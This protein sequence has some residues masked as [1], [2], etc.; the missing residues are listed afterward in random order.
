MRRRHLD[1]VI[2]AQRAATVLGLLLRNR[3]DRKQFEAQRLDSH[4][5][6]EQGRQAQSASKA[7]KALSSGAVTSPRT[8]IS[9]RP[10][11]RNTVIAVSSD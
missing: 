11:A 7:G 5:Q 9:Y 8:R 4:Q 3:V 6:A 2:R 1:W 10:P